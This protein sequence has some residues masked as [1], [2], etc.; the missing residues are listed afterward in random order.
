MHESVANIKTFMVTSYYYEAAGSL[1]SKIPIPQACNIIVEHDLLFKSKE[2]CVCRENFERWLIMVH[3]CQYEAE[4]GN[5]HNEQIYICSKGEKVNVF[6]VVTIYTLKTVQ[7][8][9]L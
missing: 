4:L 1:V 2:L 3:H 7:I 5:N 8:R 9:Y 6:A